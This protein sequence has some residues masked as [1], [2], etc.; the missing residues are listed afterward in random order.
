M[1][2]DKLT[3]F[4]VHL[5]DASFGPNV[6]GDRSEAEDEPTVE[7]E[8]PEESGISV[9]RLVVASVLFSVVVSLVAWKL[10]GEDEDPDVAIDAPEETDDA[11]DVTVDD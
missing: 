4:E 9:G 11:V 8:A 5:E 3:L 7:D 6:T 10:A 1:V 2:L